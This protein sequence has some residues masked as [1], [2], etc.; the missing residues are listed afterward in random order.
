MTPGEFLA[1]LMQLAGAFEFRITSY[2]RSPAQNLAL[3]G[4]PSSPHLFWVGADV[5][6]LEA[7][8]KERFLADAPRVGLTVIE[9]ADHFHL[10]PLG[11]TPG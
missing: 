10:Q 7:H 3:K 8:D 5:V 1:A 9:E 2:Y 4:Q 6:L 11:W